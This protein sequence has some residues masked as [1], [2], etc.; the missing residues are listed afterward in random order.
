MNQELDIEKVSNGYIVT[1]WDE[2]EEGEQIDR[3]TVIEEPDTETGELEAMQN[4]LWFVCETFGVYYSKHNKRNL[5]IE[6]Q[7]NTEGS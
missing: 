2:N 4:L 5:V 3:Q 6:I 1:E 7:D